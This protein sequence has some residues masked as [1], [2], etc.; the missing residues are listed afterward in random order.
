MTPKE[1]SIKQISELS[2]VS[3]ATVSRVI[4]HNG[5]FSKETEERVLSVIE[6][7]QYVPNMVA[8]GLRRNASQIVGIIVPDITNE[9]FAR[10]VLRLQINLFEKNFSAV[11]CN[12]NENEQLEV[13]HLQFLRAQNVSGLVFI[14][15]NPSHTQPNPNYPTVFIDRRPKD[16]MAKDTII[17]ESDNVRGGYLAGKALA[18]GGARRIATIMDSRMHT[19]GETRYQGWK[20]AMEEAGIPI[21]PELQLKVP[22]VGFN[23]AYESVSHLLKSRQSFDGLFCGTDW[24]AMGALATLHEHGVHVPSDVSVI[25]FDDVSIATFSSKPI[26]TIRQDAER[27]GDLAV[28]LL[29]RRMEG[30]KIDR[31]HRVL[32]V[33]LVRRSTTG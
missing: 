17:I 32:G 1:L 15:G 28:E 9:F 24:L 27:M 7:Y 18:E 31:P 13:S 23:A 14:S 26:T 4:N 3:T 19:A 16:V 25:G 2:G 10:I 20:K 22:L 8:R 21:L 11:I 29:L 33:E 6:Q 12:T 5:R 30:E